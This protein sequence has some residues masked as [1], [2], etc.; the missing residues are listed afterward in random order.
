MWAMLRWTWLLCATTVTTVVAEEGKW[1]TCLEGGVAYTNLL[2]ISDAYAEHRL[3]QE[4]NGGYL[5][6]AH[7]CQDSC[8]LAPGCKKFTF[9]TGSNPPGACFLIDATDDLTHRYAENDAVSGSV[10]CNFSV[11]IPSMSP[12]AG[13]AAEEAAAKTGEA[14]AGVASTGIAAVDTATSAPGTA[15]AK[16]GG[17]A[18]G[19]VSTG[20]AAVDT[21]TSAVE[22]GATKTGEAA[23]GVASTGIAAV[24]TATS[25]AETAA[26]KTG[27]AAT[28]V[29][30]ASSVA[31]KTGEAPIVTPIILPAPAKSKHADMLDDSNVGC[32]RKGVV[33]QDTLLPVPLQ[34]TSSAAGC[35]QKCQASK[36]CSLF[37]W[38][39]NTKPTGG[40]W[41]FPEPAAPMAQKADPNATSGAKD[42]SSRAAVDL[43]QGPA[44]SLIAESPSGMNSNTLWAVLGGVAVAA[45]VGGVVAFASSSESKKGKRGLKIAAQDEESATSIAPTPS[46]VP[47]SARPQGPS[48][49]TPTPGFQPVMYFQHPQLHQIQPVPQDNKNKRSVYII[50]KYLN[51]LAGLE[52]RLLAAQAVYDPASESSLLRRHM[53]GGASLLCAEPAFIQ[54]HLVSPFPASVQATPPGPAADFEDSAGQP[55]RRLGNDTGENSSCLESTCT[56]GMLNPYLGFHT[57]C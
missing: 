31:V 41:L 23:T 52:A 13:A 33:L 30:S 37:T 5:A 44:K 9:K 55:V 38:K 50:H 25:A 28:G 39:K 53:A 36:T 42:C 46:Y 27:A 57:A 16:T 15:A 3:V 43:A 14:A 7:A 19:V 56:G 21:A 2:D 17:A 54:E 26:A 40:C 51:R 45:V 4:P 32:L 35:Q 22:A 34:Y 10:A 12:P 6:N 49:A 47:S 24:D 48:I 29:A 20:I 18:T 8:K 1:P 11:V